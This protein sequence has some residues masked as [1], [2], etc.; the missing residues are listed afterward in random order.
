MKSA[1]TCLVLVTLPA[2]LVLG[3][4]PRSARA[5]GGCFAPTDTVT[6][7]EAHRMVIALSTE[8]T[9]L[10]DQIRYS[11][12]PSDF[13]WVLPAPTPEVTVEVADPAFFDEIDSQTAPRIQPASPLQPCAAGCGGG[14]A[15][16]G[17]SGDVDEP[18]MPEEDVT[19]YAEDT[20]GPYETVVIGS[21]D[22]TAL[23]TWLTERGYRIAPEV[24]PVLDYYI[25][26]GSVFVVLRLA[27]GQGIN[28][29]Q[30]VRVRYPG[31]MGTFPLKMVTVGAYG[32]L[33]LSL[34]VIAEQRYGSSNYAVR[35]INP[36][37]LVW[38]WAANRSNYG[39]LF[40]QTIADA[41]GRAW[42]VEHATPLNELYFTSA[43]ALQLYQMQPYPY[44]TRLRTRML[45]DHLSE[46]LQLQP[47]YD[48]ARVSSF[49]VASQEVNRPG[50]DC[51]PF[52]YGC[53]GGGTRTAQLLVP[54]S[55]VLLGLLWRSRRTR[56]AR[57]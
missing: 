30:P 34:W 43:E 56:R 6:S 54:M 22:S 26:T 38:D 32:L 25:Q 2:A 53:S 28:A 41:S 1:A 18:Y 23:R 50:G 4:A 7:V 36:N 10:W 13:V 49:Y 33:E 52:E 57:I 27:P 37:A 31:Y 14:A 40:D 12:N 21:E 47:S 17:G 48:W 55:I 45:V 29:M 44:V 3:A 35:A 19:V 46:D 51:G 42:I 15:G 9:I 39:E 16:G 20:V 11:G 5:C 24:D 8:Q